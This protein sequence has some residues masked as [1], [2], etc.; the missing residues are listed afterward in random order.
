MGRTMLFYDLE[1]FAEYVC[2]TAA[3]PS[4]NLLVQC[5]GCDEIREFYDKHM[6]DL[7]VGFNSKNYDTW[8]VRAIVRGYD[9]KAVN[10][11]IIGG[12]MG[13]QYASDL[14]SVQMY[15]Y[16]VMS[17]YRGL[18]EL[19][20][21]MG[22]DIRETTVPFDLKRELTDEEKAQTLY[23][24]RHDVL[25]TM[26]V[27]E[28]RFKRG[29]RPHLD[30]VKLFDLGIERLSKTPAALNGI[31]L[32]AVKRDHDDEF[33]IKFPDTL[34]L[35]R[36]RFVLDWYKNED[37][38]TYEKTLNCTI[39]GIPFQFG[40][41]GL[42]GASTSTELKNAYIIDCDARSLYPSLMI[43]YDYFSRNIPLSAKEKY[44]EIYWNRINAKK[45]GNKGISE[46]LKLA[47]NST[48]GCYKDRTNALYDPQMGNNI[49]VAGQL[50]L[51]D[52]IE[53]LEDGVKSFRLW[54]ANTDGIFFS[55]DGSEEEFDRID[56]IVYEFEQRTRLV[57]E[58]D[59]YK[60][61]YQAN[62]N[63]YIAVAMDGKG[64]HSKGIFFKEKTEL[65]NDLPIVLEAIM[66]KILEG[67]PIRETIY[68]CNDLMMFQHV[69]KL[70]KNFS[71]CT[72]NGEV[73]RDRNYRI[74]VSNDGMDDML[75]KVN[76]KGRKTAFLK[77][78][79]FIDNSD[80]KGK[81]VPEKLDRDWYVYQAMARYDVLRDKNMMGIFDPSERGGVGF[82][83][84]EAYDRFR[85]MHG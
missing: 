66:R 10:D 13:W 42:H 14:S 51:L 41:G 77:E 56:D 54:N 9:P 6:D 45:E 63:N 81:P 3:I 76:S 40:W 8:I 7:W 22:D 53:K 37:N 19:E 28:K 55:Y 5:E 58:F 21:F 30:L 65:D 73:L 71:Y 70:S 80:V 61:L 52:L 59:W 24:N 44:K 79:V 67:K 72:H 4:Q 68:E 39:A 85:R 25:E 57:M 83:T 50:L 26:R 36:Y 15:Q 23:Y 12:K 31:I 48:Y 11:W 17:G 29:F 35:D 60:D 18:K 20:A 82:I 47:L 46:A 32:G 38:R 43:E 64:V 2:M 1:V 69:V 27:F 16:D 62:V 34:R 75:F 33:D 74:F 49:C 78:R 84:R